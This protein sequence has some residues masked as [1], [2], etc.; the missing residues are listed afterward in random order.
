MQNLSAI[1]CYD[2]PLGFYQLAYD[3][4]EPQKL[5]KLLLCTLSYMVRIELS[6]IKKQNMVIFYNFISICCIIK[7]LKDLKPTLTIG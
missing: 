2:F 1:D 5:L 7:C 4:P 6:S 3:A